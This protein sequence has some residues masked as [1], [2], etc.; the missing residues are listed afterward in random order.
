M[1]ARGENTEFNIG[2][3]VYCIGFYKSNISRCMF[4]LSVPG[5]MPAT[6]AGFSWLRLPATALT[7]RRQAQQ[8]LAHVQ[9]PNAIPTALNT[10]AG[11]ARK[12]PPAG[13]RQRA[14]Q[15]GIAA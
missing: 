1:R 12:T 13:K 10:P 9:P 4:L 3:G 15:T 11:G 8:G 5:V 6:Q 7:Q 14:W 2:H